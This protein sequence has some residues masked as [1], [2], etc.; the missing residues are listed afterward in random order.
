[1]YIRKILFI[2]LALAEW[3]EG[4]ITKCADY[5]EI[6]YVMYEY[7]DHKILR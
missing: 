7:L 5:S 1:M 4:F 2:Y 3:K 6:N